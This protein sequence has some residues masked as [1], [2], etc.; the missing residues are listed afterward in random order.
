[1]IGS[2]RMLS[3]SSRTLR[4]S[5]TNVKAVPEPLPAAIPTVQELMRSFIN[6]SVFSPRRV[7]GISCAQAGHVPKASVDTTAS[8]ATVMRH[9]Q[10]NSA[11]RLAEAGDEQ[12]RSCRTCRL[13]D[14]YRLR[15][16]VAQLNN[17]ELERRTGARG[18]S[19]ARAI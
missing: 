13:G 12:D 5:S 10:R 2:T 7:F 6:C 3:P 15:C 16:F 8:V 18:Q 19:G 1:M 4:I 17:A 11:D 9:R 14:S